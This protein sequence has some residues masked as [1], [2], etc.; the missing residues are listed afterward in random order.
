M[1]SQ[2]CHDFTWDILYWAGMPAVW[3]G[4]RDSLQTNFRFTH[5]EQDWNNA[6]RKTAT[7]RCGFLKP[8]SASWGKNFL[9]RQRS[10]IW[11]PTIYFYYWKWKGKVLVN[12]SC[13]TLWDP[14]DCSS[15]GFSIHGI[16]QAR[17]L[18]WVAISFSRGS[19]WPRDQ[20]RFSCIAGRFFTYC[21]NHQGS[22]SHNNL[23]LKFYGL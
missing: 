22:Y 18:E 9:G 3:L 4:V 14:M 20:T 1:P 10:R 2:V 19:S 11:L 6:S 23:I 17:V 12:Q 13:P 16:L 7:R 5:S 8:F 21:M 15:P